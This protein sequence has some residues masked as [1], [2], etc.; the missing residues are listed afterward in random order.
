MELTYN[1][2]SGESI[3][4]SWT[5]RMKPVVGPHL[6]ATPDL[7]KPGFLWTVFQN[8]AMIDNWIEQAEEALRG[9]LTDGSGNFIGN[10]AN[11]Q[12]QGPAMAPGTKVGSGENAA[13]RFEIP[14]T[15]NLSQSGGG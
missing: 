2:P 11:P 3:A 14:T 10:N 9:E 7:T 13:V 15:I 12:I 1:P 5:H 8:A 4:Q 6:M